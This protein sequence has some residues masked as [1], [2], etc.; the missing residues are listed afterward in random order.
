MHRGSHALQFDVFNALPGLAK[1]G[2]ERDH[3]EFGTDAFKSIDVQFTA[4]A[5]VTSPPPP[6]PHVQVPFP[7]L[8]FL[9]PSLAPLYSLRDT[10]GPSDRVHSIDK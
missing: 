4:N 5:F 6:S 9:V 3:H 2:P 8:H 10:P 7:K 1:R